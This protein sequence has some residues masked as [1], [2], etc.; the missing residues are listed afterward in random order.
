MDGVALRVNWR[1]GELA[2][3]NDVRIAGDH[4]TGR[5]QHYHQHCKFHTASTISTNKPH[6][7]V[8]QGGRQVTLVSKAFYAG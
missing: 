7:Y 3:E 2:K 1:V 8:D 6:A 4:R 5:D